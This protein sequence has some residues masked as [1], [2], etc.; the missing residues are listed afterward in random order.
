MIWEY[1]TAIIELIPTVYESDGQPIY[2]VQETDQFLNLMGQQ[3][4]ELVDANPI[5]KEGITTHFAYFFKRPSSIRSANVPE[6][7][8]D[9]DNNGITGSQL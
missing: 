7:G 6:I 4:W 9:I 2:V 1:K 3:H 5:L 8:Y